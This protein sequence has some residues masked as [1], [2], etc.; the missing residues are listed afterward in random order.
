LSF[1]G[2]LVK[3]GEKLSR[4]RRL[5]KKKGLTMKELGQKVGKTEACI[6]QYETGIRTPP[7][8]VAKKLAAALGC[9]WEELYEEDEAG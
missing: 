1:L 5:R 9:V 4:L 3:G 8:S 2:F 7:V 6:C